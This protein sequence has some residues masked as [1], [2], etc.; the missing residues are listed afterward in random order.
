MKNSRGLDI[1]YLEFDHA[2]LISD[3][4]FLN[5]LATFYCSIWMYDPAF[6]EYKKCPVCEKYYS[7]QEV[8]VGGVAT[9]SGKDSP[10]PVANLIPAWNPEDVAN[11]ELLGNTLKYGNYFYG[12][13]ALDKSTGK[14]VGFTW[15][16]LESIEKI[17]AEWGDEITSKLGNVNST[18]YSE[19][20][21]DPNK[22][23]RGKRIGKELCSRLVMWMKSAHPEI[24]SFLR[25]HKKSCAKKMFEK[26]GYR[27]FAD[28]P[29][30]GD[31]RI[32]MMVEKGQ[33]L[34]P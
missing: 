16:W 19:I 30:H 5:D 7:E 33:D 25:T 1:E 3:P 8:E 10:H 31:G 22:A 15:G 23:Y 27:Y 26:A 18:Y 2:K 12:I 9:C 32:M 17:K 29:Q 4:V 14:I 13:Y 6:G 21:V 20:A 11:E 24:P 34:V 28:D